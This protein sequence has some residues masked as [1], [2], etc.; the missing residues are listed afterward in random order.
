MKNCDFSFEAVPLKA[1][2]DAARNNKLVFF[3]GSGFSKFSETLLLKIPSWA[4]LID[5]LKQDL[6]CH[7]ESDFLKIAQL[8]FIKF[9]EHLYVNKTK[10]FFPQDLLPSEFHKNLYKL[11]PHY[12]ITTNWDDLLE[13]TPIAQREAYELVCSDD[14]LSQCR[15]DKKI[16]KMHGDFDH[17]NFVFKEDDYLQYSHH[18][19]LIENY[20]KGVFTTHTVVFLGYSYNDY[21]LK[22]IVT[23]INRISKATPPKYL[24]AKDFDDGQNQYLKNHCITL[25][26]PVLPCDSH[27]E[28]YERF[29]DDLDIVDYPVASIK[30]AVNRFSEKEK[31]AKEKSEAGHVQQKEIDQLNLRLDREVENY[32]NSVFKV[33][34]QYQRLLSV[35]VRQKLTNCTM[36]YSDNKSV[37]VFHK[38]LLTRDYDAEMR[39]V[40]H[41]CFDV[42]LK[43]SGAGS[44]LF[45]STLAKAGISQVEYDGQR[46]RVPDASFYFPGVI[47]NFIR[48]IEFN[49]HEDDVEVYFLNENYKKQLEFFFLQV[50]K[51]LADKNYVMA[52][53]HM[54]NFDFV[55]RYIQSIS[56]GL[57]NKKVKEVVDDFSAFDY[58]SRLTDFPSDMQDDLRDL[59][60]YLEFDKIYKAFCEFFMQSRRNQGLA[61]KRRCGGFAYSADEYTL[62]QKLYEYV[63]FILMNDIYID[64]FKEI[65]ELFSSVILE[66][67]EH[68][69]IEDQFVASRLDLFV[70]IKY[71]EKEQVRSLAKKLLTD[72]RFVSVYKSGGPKADAN[73]K[74]YLMACLRNICKLSGFM[75]RNTMGMNYSRRWLGSILIVLG[76]CRWREHDVEKIMNCILPV[77]KGE[78]NDLDLYDDLC[79]FLSIHHDLYEIS[80]PRILGILDVVLTKIVENKSN[81]FD[82]EAIRQ[83]RL[84]RLFAISEK[85]NYQYENSALL[86]EVLAKLS[87]SGPINQSIYIDNLLKPIHGIGSNEVKECIDGFVSQ[88]RSGETPR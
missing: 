9:G 44:A 55:Y 79:N 34:Q 3:V 48:K 24:L 80:S 57:R 82:F 1:I 10:S 81:G 25:L 88:S 15:L 7:A 52:T 6:D 83:G 20:I 69:L 87:T 35:Q 85:K 49:Y 11:K 17:H 78:T 56:H 21:N 71:F 12:I 51:F 68:Y 19:P 40:L 41:R 60:G 73:I 58:K 47:N 45:L 53:I 8:Y 26:S 63:L 28:L 86:K 46:Q 38:D 16:I 33:L 22:Q 30:R 65:R 62:R 70:V 4:E 54:A 64:D 42:V 23:W 72:K 76:F 37:L 27:E 74:Q 77:L 50:Q 5:E 75:A 31:V 18:F 14:D 61:E 59:V 2:M 29:F 13:K 84:E 67:I 36:E 32:I 43:E 39:A 66:S